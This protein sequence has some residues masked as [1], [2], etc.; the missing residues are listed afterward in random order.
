[1]NEAPAMSVLVEQSSGKFPV[2]LKSLALCKLVIDIELRAFHS[3]SRRKHVFQLISSV[4]ILVIA[5][6]VMGPHGE[7][8]P[9]AFLLT[10]LMLAES[11][12]F[13]FLISKRLIKL[14]FGVHNVATL[15]L[16]PLE[17]KQVPTCKFQVRHGESVASR[18]RTA[19]M[20][21]EVALPTCS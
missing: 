15:L 4:S 19:W 10:N 2:R 16:K 12:K 11:D 1:M 5:L 18:V 20:R 3:T 21:S 13:Q 7:L 8:R 17:H 6:Q 14:A 9:H